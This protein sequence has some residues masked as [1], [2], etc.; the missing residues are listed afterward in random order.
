M[1]PF[2]IHLLIFPAS[3]IFLVTLIVT[4]HLLKWP[5]IALISATVKSIVFLFYFGVVFDGTF[6]FSDDLTYL[7]GGRSLLTA[8]VGLTN[9]AQNWE[10]ALEVGRGDHFLYYLF[11][12]YALRL[13]SDGYFAPVALN[14]VLTIFVAYIGAVLASREFNLSRSTTKLFYL[15]LLFHPDIF[16]WSNIMNGKDI[17]VLL[18]HILMLHSVSLFFRRELWQALAIGVPVVLILFFLRFYVPLLILTALLLS[19]LASPRVTFRV[20]MRLLFAGSSLMLLVL[21]WL[22]GDG[23][24]YALSKIGENFVNPI[25]GFIR[26]MLTPIPFRT[27]T[28]YAFLDLPAIFHWLMMP[29]VALGILK[30]Y[31]FLTPFSLFFIGYFLLFVG[32]YSVFGELQGPRHRVQLD[33]AFALF[34]FLGLIMIVRSLRRSLIQRHV[35]SAHYNAPVA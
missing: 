2:D 11:N 4:F 33:F 1:S 26:M 23:I 30:I 21:A 22:G 3:V 10:Y 15:F 27:E 20:R 19:I 12:T 16:V 5:A 13:F 14:I 24:G 9:L 17:L 34:Q 29:F 28:A 6:T 7:D 25:Y 18:L 31:R 35:R 32:L 8:D